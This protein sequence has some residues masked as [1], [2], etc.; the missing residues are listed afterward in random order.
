MLGNFWL[1]S[2]RRQQNYPLDESNT[3]TSSRDRASSP[4]TSPRPTTFKQPL[5]RSVEAGLYMSLLHH[6]MESDDL[7]TKEGTEALADHC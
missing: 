1:L 3:C 7:I 2:L 5:L 6:S 4:A